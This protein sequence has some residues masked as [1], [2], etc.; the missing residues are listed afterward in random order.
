MEQKEVAAV[1][2]QGRTPMFGNMWL[3]R[4]MISEIVLGSRAPEPTFPQE[5]PQE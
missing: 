3:G 2:R 4:G 5:T 1:R